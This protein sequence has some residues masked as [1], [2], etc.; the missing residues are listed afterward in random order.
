MEHGPRVLKAKCCE[1]LGNFCRKC[2][3][4][5]TVWGQREP[6]PKSLG[7]SWAAKGI[8]SQSFPSHHSGY[9]RGV[10]S[11]SASP[12]LRGTLWGALRGGPP[13]PWQNPVAP[14]SSSFLLQK[15]VKHIL[16]FT[17]WL[18]TLLHSGLQ[19]CAVGLTSYPVSVLPQN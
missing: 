8:W 17:A 6:S 15:A 4:G 2:C 7:G 19:R 5:S 9:L 13:L 11:S 3:S 12:R 1:A 18:S 14:Q 10:D 16:F